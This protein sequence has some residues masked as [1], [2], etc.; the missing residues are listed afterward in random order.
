MSSPQMFQKVGLTNG[1][2]VLPDRIVVEQALL[3]E[4]GKILGIASPGELEL[5]LPKVDVGGRFITPGLIDIH[6]HGAVGHSFNEPDEQAWKAITLEQ[7][8]H[9][10]TALAATL[11]TDALDNL[12]ACLDFGR[13]WHNTQGCAQVLGMHLEGPFFNLNQKGAQNPENIR[14]PWDGSSEHLLE[15]AET[16]RILTYAPELPGALE[17]TDRLVELGIL[18]AAGHSSAYDTHILAAIDR[19]L[20]HT[21]HIWSSQS[22]VVREGPWRKPGLLE[23]TLAFD[24]LTAEMI[25]DNRHLPPTLMKLAYKCKGAD[26]LCV[27]SDASSG[28]GLPEGSRI[29]LCGLECEI[30]DGVAMLLDHS[31]FAGSTTLLDRMI[32]VLIVEVGIPVV[33]AVRMAS[34]TPARIIG[35]EARKGSLETGKDA[36]IAIFDADFRCWKTII[37]GEWD[38]A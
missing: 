28:A 26:N 3:F 10:V 4:D 9:G 23:A 19:G 20:R 2:I 14:L 33:E 25:A 37:G 7:A 13:D 1:K 15:Y 5:D 34:L 6:T 12:C 36:D 16:I 38:L 22:T 29:E 27:V 11:A 24:Q 17:L 21:V 31:S 35:V 32:D 18:P 8:R 30:R